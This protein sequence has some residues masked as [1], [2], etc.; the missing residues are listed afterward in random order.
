MSEIESIAKVFNELG[1]SA[2][3][4]PLLATVIVFYF[5]KKYIF[6]GA[7]DFLKN[8]TGEY[9]K[10]NNERIALE[11]KINLKLCELTETLDKFI[12]Q[13]MEVEKQSS[14]RMDSLRV[15]L[16][17]RMNNIEVVMSDKI[18]RELFELKTNFL[19]HYDDFAENNHVC[20]RRETDPPDSEAFT[21]RKP[22]FST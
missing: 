6:S 10:Q 20:A 8:V 4:A 2:L 18:F 16:S 1:I 15:D 19:N 3:F 13:L 21:K 7:G 14:E 22:R 12:G 5:V 11:T 9:L 17:N